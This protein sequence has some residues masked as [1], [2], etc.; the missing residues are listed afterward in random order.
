MTRL[1]RNF[2][3]AEFEKSQLASRFNVNNKATATAIKNLKALCD[4]ILQPLRDDLDR[5]IHINSGYR[6]L[7]LNRKIGSK[8]TSQHIFGEAADIEVPGLS[9]EDLYEYIQSSGLPFDQV[10]LE[11]HTKGNPASG[12]VHVSHVSDPAK[13]RNMALELPKISS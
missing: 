6:C 4:N 5:G 8:D 3:L 12:W 13:N 9:N 7:E 2:T 10:I 11:Y 1:S